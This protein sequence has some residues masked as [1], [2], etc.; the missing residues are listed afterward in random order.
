[1]SANKQPKKSSSRV[2]L[3]PPT[4][5]PPPEMRAG[6]L[7]RRKS[8]L[9]AMLDNA[10]RGDW[11]PVMTIANHIRGTGAMYGFDSIGNAAE[12]L[13]KAVGNGDPKSLEY[14]EEYVTAVKK[15][16]V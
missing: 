3:D 8:E 9:D 2:I 6:Y 12:N 14:M 5:S 7:E 1:M 11:K 4:Y 15:S 10:R 16:S 13:V